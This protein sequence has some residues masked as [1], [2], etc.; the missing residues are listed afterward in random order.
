MMGSFGTSYQRQSGDEV[1]LPK[2][3]S[4]VRDNA[5]KPYRPIRLELAMY[6]KCSAQLR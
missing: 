5:G 1:A 4:L 3:T 2:H 6:M